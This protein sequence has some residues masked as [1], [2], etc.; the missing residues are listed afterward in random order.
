MKCNGASLV[1]LLFI[2]LFGLTPPFCHSLLC[3]S[4]DIAGATST[5]SSSSYVDHEEPVLHLEQHTSFPAKWQQEK[6]ED[7]EQLFSRQ[8]EINP[9]LLCAADFPQEYINMQHPE[10]YTIQDSPIKPTYVVTQ[11]RGHARL[12]FRVSWKVGIGKFMPMSFIVDTGAIQPIYFGSR[13]LKLMERHGRL[14]LD[15]LQNDVVLLEGLGGRKVHYESTPKNYEP[16][17]L[18]GLRFLLQFGLHIVGSQTFYFNVSFEY[19]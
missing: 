6:E 1:L 18:I 4:S 11:R 17:N 14:L 3:S 19:F 15:D 16:T 12:I 8:D 2:H 13:S 7:P 5:S 9:I 10:D